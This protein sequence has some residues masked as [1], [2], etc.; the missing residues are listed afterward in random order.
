MSFHSGAGNYTLDFSG[1]LSRDMHVNIGSGMSTVTIIMPEGVSAVLT[2][3]SSL[4]TI[5]ASGE[6][7]QSGNTFQHPG[8]GYTITIDAEIGAGTLRLETDS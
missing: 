5:N 8:S 7:T 3:D 1:Q 4:I 6:W 2:N